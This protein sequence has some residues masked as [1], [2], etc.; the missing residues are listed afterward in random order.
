VVS[1]LGEYLEQRE[2]LRHVEVRQGAA[3]DLSSIADDSRDLVI[4]N[5]VIQYFPDL[6]YLLEVLSEAVR[7]TAPG[8]H[9]FVGDVRSLPLLEAYHTSVQL[10]KAAD[11]VTSGELRQQVRQAERNEE[12]LVVDPELFSELGRRLAKVGRV[13]AELKA[14]SYDNEL[15]R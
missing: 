15:S 13:K 9:I 14:G 11:E 3:H 4:I 7:I 2:D 6:D 5:S 1:Q 8:G 12:E 10:Y